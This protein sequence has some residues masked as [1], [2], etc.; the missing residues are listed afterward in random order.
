MI[1]QILKRSLLIVTLVVLGTITT[2]AGDGYEV[3]PVN[4]WMISPFVLLLLSIAIIPFLSRHW[5]ERYYPHVS[6]GLGAISVVYYVFFLQNADRMLHTG[7]EYISFIILIGSLFVVAGGIHIRIKGKSTPIANVILLGIGAIVSNL[8]G[9]TGA[10]MILIRPY[11]RVNK[12]RLR[13]FHVVF[14]IFIVSN[15][16]GA[17][18]PIGDPPLFLGYLKGVPFFWVLLSLWHVWALAIG[19][20]LLI[21]FVFDYLSFK[22]YEKHFKHLDESKFDEEAEVNGLHNIIFLLIILVSVFIQRPIF[23]REFL[24][25]IAA[26]G[27]YTMTKKE[28]HK[29]NDFNFIPIKE[30]AILF[31]GIFATMVPA[32]D[33]LE[34]NAAKIGITSAG[35]FY[36]GTGILSSFL[37][38]APTYLNY[39]SASIGLFVDQ[40]IVAQVQHLIATK[41]TDIASIAG[42][43]GEEIK[44]T[45][46][47]LMKYHADLVATGNVPLSD[48]QVSY[49]IGNHDI[50][51]KAISI[52]AVFFGAVTYIGNGPNFMVKSIAEQSGAKCPSF[53]GYIARY[54]LPILIP[55]FILVW[56]CFFRG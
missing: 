7:M 6:I 52:A 53:G 19:I 4:P 32:L 15:M 22:K 42:T 26:V 49:L 24:M 17:L 13:P 16:G 29:K 39:L 11:L 35:Q 20:I 14:F 18:T 48:I 38:N 47:V 41:G 54:A 44:N 55:V 37:D 36:W 45:F 10:S 56:L 51:L 28:I 2:F 5:W 3:L 12:Y 27:S 43:H 33:W 8:L 34:L 25:I 40:N 50:Y 23:L 30:V 21:F 31:L 9:T 46:A 1:Y